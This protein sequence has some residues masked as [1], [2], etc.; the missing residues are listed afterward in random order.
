MAN[1]ESLPSTV[2]HPSDNTL[3]KHLKAS[4]IGDYDNHMSLQLYG[5]KTTQASTLQT[6]MDSKHIRIPSIIKEIPSNNAAL[7]PKKE[8]K[9]FEL[10]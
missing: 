2:T 8:S 4:G 7:K 5:E 6:Q 1:M 10:I 3:I 9:A